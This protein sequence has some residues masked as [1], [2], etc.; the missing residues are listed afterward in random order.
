LGNGC[1]GHRAGHY[2]FYFQLGS[3]VISSR[4]LNLF[5]DPFLMWSRLAWKAGEMAIASAPVIG[6]RTGRLA[7]AS[8]VTT[9]RDQREFALMG[10]EKGRAALE[11]AQAAGVRMLMMNQ[12][13][14]AL[15]FKQML[16]ASAAL[17]SIAASRTAAE[18]VHRQ[19]KLVRDTLNNSVA[20]T[21]K[22]SSGAAQLARRALSPVHARV[23][24]NVRRLGRTSR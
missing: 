4:A 18:S 8:S 24:G 7:L 15:A 17:L 11:S 23:R 9:A 13:F 14:A 12:Q 2:L 1:A 6:H 5:I 10:Q 16:S 22:L 21:S 3:T 20:A 19:S